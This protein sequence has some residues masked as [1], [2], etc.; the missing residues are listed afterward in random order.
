[1]KN[2]LINFIKNIFSGLLTGIKELFIVVFMISILLLI[3]LIPSAIIGIITTLIIKDSMSLLN[4]LNNGF[5]VEGCLMLGCAFLWLV[6]KSIINFIKWIIRCW[7]ESE[8]N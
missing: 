4:I 3:L 6:I 8:E 5:D 7:K 1:M 2:R